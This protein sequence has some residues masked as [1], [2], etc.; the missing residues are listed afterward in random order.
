MQAVPTRCAACRVAWCAAPPH[1]LRA[2][3][4]RCDADHRM[5][6][7]CHTNLTDSARLNVQHRAVIACCTS[8]SVYSGFV[9]WVHWLGKSTVATSPSVIDAM[10]LRRLDWQSQ[11]WSSE[12]PA[13]LM[14]LLLQRSRLPPHF[15]LLPAVQQV[16]TDRDVPLILHGC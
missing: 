15:A 5:P 13:C 8:G 12:L 4:A 16:V 7:Q 14:T 3:L 6:A 10:H 9:C 1:Q 2:T 11:A